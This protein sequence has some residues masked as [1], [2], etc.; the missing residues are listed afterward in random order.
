M[1][2]M[3]EPEATYYDCYATG[4]KG[5]VQFYVEEARTAG[6]PVLELGCGT[7]R[8]LIPIAEAG[9]EVV[10]LDRSSVML[11]QARRKVAFLAP[12]VQERVDLIEG[13]MGDFALGRR[14]NLVAIPYRAF[15][16]LP[17]PEDERQ[18]LLNIRDHL[19]EGGL[20]VM[21]MFDP[22]LELIAGHSGPL[23]AALKKQSEF[24]HPET[25]H[26]VVIWDSRQ[27]DPERQLVD[28]NFVFDEL[29]EVG[30]V[31]ARR[32]TSYS[33]RYVYRQEMQYLLEL[34]GFRIEALYGDFQRGP[35][36]Y[37]G[38]QIWVARR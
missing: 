6:S 19:V 10:G 27:Y 33:L 31:L 20:L 12:D 34:C 8:I 32:Y 25:G 26:R 9:I 24:T 38:E 14:F 5:D 23:G 18:A 17:T 21:N 36:R 13:G 30:Q 4:L 7:G 3:P 1:T 35:F 2:V 15:L 28:Q 16:H 29:D 11:D 37:G 22:L